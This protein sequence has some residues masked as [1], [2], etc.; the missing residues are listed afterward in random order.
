MSNG[1][2]KTWTDQ[3][4]PCIGLCYLEFV[5]VTESREAWKRTIEAATL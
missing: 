5:H 1:R 3:V 2:P 4:K